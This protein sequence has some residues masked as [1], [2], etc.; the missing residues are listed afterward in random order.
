MEDGDVIRL[1]NEM[2]R[3]IHTPGHTAGSVCI[4][5]GQGEAGFYR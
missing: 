1:G 5:F 2:I 4:F 3:V